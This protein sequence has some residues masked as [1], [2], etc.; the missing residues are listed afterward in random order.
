MS[1]V[2]NS[3]EFQPVGVKYHIAIEVELTGVQWLYL[4][5]LCCKDA[6]SVSASSNCTCRALHHLLSL[7]CQIV[8]LHLICESLYQ[9]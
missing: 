4:G 7:V 5:I 2:T 8:Y 3:S 6:F 9:V 1:K